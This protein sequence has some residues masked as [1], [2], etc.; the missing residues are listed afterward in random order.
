MANAPRYV[1][2]ATHDGH[3]QITRLFDFINP[4]AIALWNLRWQVKGFWDSY[5]KATHDTLKSRFALGS[6]LKGGELYRACIDTTWDQQLESFAGI[7]LV[8]AIATFEDFTQSVV[9]KAG[10]TPRRET[11]EAMQFPTKTAPNKPNG[12]DWAFAKFGPSLPSLRSVFYMNHVTRR[13]AGFNLNNLLTCFRYFKALRNMLAHNGGRATQQMVD[14]YQAFLPVANTTALGLAE[15]PTHHPVTLNQPV[16]VELRGVIGLCDV[17]LRIMTT[18]DAELSDRGVALVEFD[19]RTPPLPARLNL[20]PGDPRKRLERIQSLIG[21][22]RFPKAAITTELI[23][24]M[25]AT[26]KLPAYW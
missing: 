20:P 11:Y 3:S 1:L 23:D 15:V 14:A 19:D 8:N 10:A 25:K 16:K 22:G 5:P 12:H 9:D 7:V 18:Y 13:Y 24:H 26:N 2:S 21:A 6:G 4:A 17:I